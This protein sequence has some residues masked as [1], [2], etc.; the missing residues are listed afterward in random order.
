MNFGVM[1]Y[2]M[3][4][5]MA[6]LLLVLQSAFLVA[7]FLAKDVPLYVRLV[8]QVHVQLDVQV[9]V[10]V[11]IHQDIIYVEADKV[12]VESHVLQDV[13]LVVHRDVQVLA[14][15]QVQMDLEMLLLGVM[16]FV[17]QDV[18]LGVL[19]LASL[20]TNE[21]DQVFSL[22]FIFFYLHLQTLF[23]NSLES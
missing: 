19:S 20:P 10:Q 16:G 7:I 12:D 22:V 23:S 14:P 11:F 8:V 15:L 3:L 6:V 9:Y 2:A 17:L 1:V 4:I 5:V 21:K 13:L 18:L